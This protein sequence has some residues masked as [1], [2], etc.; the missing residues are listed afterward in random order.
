MKPV[1][2]NRLE[3]GTGTSINEKMNRFIFIS[4]GI[5]HNVKFLIK[6]QYFD[7]NIFIKLSKKIFHLLKNINIISKMIS[8]ISIKLKNEIPKKRPKMPPISEIKL[9]ISVLGSSLISVYFNSL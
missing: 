9:K 8:N 4:I 7:C 6:R 1:P 5:D 3:N 2:K